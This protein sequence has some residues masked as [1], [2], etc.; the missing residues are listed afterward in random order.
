MIE[1]AISLGREKCANEQAN[2]HVGVPGFQRSLPRRQSVG[3]MRNISPHMQVLL[4][5]AVVGRRQSHTRR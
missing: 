1:R 3:I 5:Q 2:T 4:E